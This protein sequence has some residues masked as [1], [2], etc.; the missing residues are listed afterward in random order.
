MYTNIHSNIT[1]YSN[2]Q[3]KCVSVEGIDK[4]VV[5]SSNGI[6]LSIKK[7]ILHASI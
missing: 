5:Y 3:P 2:K 6:L 1:Y 7:E 4:F